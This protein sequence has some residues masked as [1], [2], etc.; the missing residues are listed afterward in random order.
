MDIYASLFWD[1]DTRS[2]EFHGPGFRTIG[3][4][5]A[6]FRRNVVLLLGPMC[7][8]FRTGLFFFFP[9]HEVLRGE[10]ASMG[11]FRQYPCARKFELPV[12]IAAL[13]A[14]DEALFL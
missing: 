4:N 8:W 5:F 14:L 11:L 9:A 3:H 1:G 10:F 6:T 7:P 12:E 13:A 2:L